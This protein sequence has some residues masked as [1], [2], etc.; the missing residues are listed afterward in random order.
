MVNGLYIQMATFLQP[1][2]ERRLVS[3]PQ[4]GNKACTVYLR[5]PYDSGE[6]MTNFLLSGG[7]FFFFLRERERVGGKGT[8]FLFCIFLSRTLQPTLTLS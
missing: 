8:M 4:A 2:T 7:I 5:L 3:S 6:L 1:C